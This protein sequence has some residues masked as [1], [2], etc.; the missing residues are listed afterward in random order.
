MELKQAIHNISEGSFARSRQQ[1][2]FTSVTEA[3]RSDAQRKAV[4]AK[5]KKSP[6]LSDDENRRVER[7]IS[8]RDRMLAKS[9][10]GDT[11]D[12]D[13]DGDKEKGKAI[14]A[15]LARGRV[16]YRKIKKK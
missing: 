10:S 15:S 9:L 8:H 16:I 11:E 4:M 5:R 12:D 7:V 14:R 3:F 2:I 13:N 1:E 6:G